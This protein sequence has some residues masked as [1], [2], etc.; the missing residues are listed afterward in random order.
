MLIL[1]VKHRILQYIGPQNL[2]LSFKDHRHVQHP[3]YLSNQNIIRHFA[4]LIYS[5]L[6]LDPVLFDDVLQQAQVIWVCAE[7]LKEGQTVEV[8]EDCFGVDF[9][10]V[11]VGLLFALDFLNVHHVDG[12][13]GAE[14]LFVRGEGLRGQNEGTVFVLGEEGCFLHVRVFRVQVPAKHKPSRLI[15]L[16]IIKLTRL[17]QKSHFLVLIQ[18]PHQENPRKRYL[19]NIG[20]FLSLLRNMQI[21]L[22]HLIYVVVVLSRVM[23]QTPH[24]YQCELHLL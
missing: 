5:H 3:V 21:L 19:N 13:E 9:V 10:D 6:V 23:A 14:Q 7:N 16:R 12:G 18:I 24:I 1:N 22:R 20:P 4:R 15:M 17:S 8:L 11:E 2:V